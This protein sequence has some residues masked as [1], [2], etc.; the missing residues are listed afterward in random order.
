MKIDL[1]RNSGDWFFRDGDRVVSICYEKLVDWFDLPEDVKNITLD[2]SA[3][4]FDIGEE[5]VS[6]YYY[7]SVHEGFLYDTYGLTKEGM[8]ESLNVLCP[9]VK[10][11]VQQ[12][13]LPPQGVLYVSLEYME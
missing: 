4:N 1:K 3:A 2:V 9:T 11:I 7:P 6:V 13:D 8:L 12:M 10:Y 5:S